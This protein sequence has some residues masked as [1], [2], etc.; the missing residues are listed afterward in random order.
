MKVKIQYLNTEIETE[1]PSFGSKITE[2]M[3]AESWRIYAIN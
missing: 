2:V 1:I 3:K